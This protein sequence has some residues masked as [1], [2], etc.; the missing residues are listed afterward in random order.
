MLRQAADAE[1]RLGKHPVSPG[2]FVPIREQL[3]ELLLELDRAKD[4]QIAFEAALKIYPGRFR[5]LY[6]AGQAA[7]RSGEK[8]KARSYYA[9]LAAQT[10][11][12][13]ESREELTRIRKYLATTDAETK[14][15]KVAAIQD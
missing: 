8:E 3:G 4:A 1:D 13:E 11:N 12:A 9:K 6:G 15:R 10:A 14:S 7:E 5:G 2:A